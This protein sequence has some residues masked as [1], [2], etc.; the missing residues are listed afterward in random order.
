MRPSHLVKRAVNFATR[1]FFSS[2]LKACDFVCLMCLLK[3]GENVNCKSPLLVII[4][5]RIAVQDEG[6]PDS[7]DNDR[8]QMLIQSTRNDGNIATGCCR[9][10]FLQSAAGRVMKVKVGGETG[11]VRDAE[12]VLELLAAVPDGSSLRLD[13]NQA[14]SIE[15]ALAFC[16]V[17]ERGRDGGSEVDGSA[18]EQGQ[19]SI[20]SKIEY[21][22]EPLRDPRMLGEFWERSGKALPYALDESLGTGRKS[23]LQDDVRDELGLVSYG[24][25][26]P[27]GY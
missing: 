1:L 2:G 18:L 26:G 22:E 12:Y 23:A 19:G 24:L 3:A 25:T 4:K 10:A 7:N 20:R 14:W 5:T 27:H 6:N 8:Y 11:P 21:L 13:A 17:I 15:D 9:T 16:E